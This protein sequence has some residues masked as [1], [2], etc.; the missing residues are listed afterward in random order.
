MTPSLHATD[1]SLCSF[2]KPGGV[3]NNLVYLYK[4]RNYVNGGV[5]DEQVL[6]GKLLYN[7]EDSGSKPELRCQRLPSLCNYKCEL[8]AGAGGLVLKASA[9]GGKAR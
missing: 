6:T 9:A 1:N 5:L 7:N 2:G 8:M 3:D 4:G